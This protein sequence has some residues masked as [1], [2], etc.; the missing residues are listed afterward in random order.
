M[1][2]I[3]KNLKISQLIFRHL[4]D[5][6]KQAEKDQLKKIFQESPEYLDLFNKMKDP[7][8]LGKQLSKYKE[9]KLDQKWQTLQN[10]LRRKQIKRNLVFASKLAAILIIPVLIAL[11]AIFNNP[12]KGINYKKEFTA[13]A[14]P[15]SSKVQLITEKGEVFELDETKNLN[16]KD[17]LVKIEN[18]KSEL[19]YAP[20][21]DNKKTLEI[22]YHT[23]IVP[24][25][26]EHFL[27]LSDGTRIWVNSQSKLKYP[28]TFIGETRSIELIEGEIY[29]EVAHNKERP[30][31]VQTKE[32]IVKVL[33]T[34][35]N[36][37]AYQDEIKSY[38]TLVKGSISLRHKFEETLEVILKPGEQA[39]QID[40]N[41]TIKVKQVDIEP[42]IAWKNGNFIFAAD[43]MEDIFNQLSRWYGFE[44]AYAD[45]SVKDIKFRGNF[46]KNEGIIKILDLL[47]ETKK[48]KFE[49][50][51]K[52]IIVKR[53]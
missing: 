4:K 8:Y 5:E 47:E 31:T 43:R 36:I 53:N 50:Q 39:E 51:E 41:H 52:Q 27:T 3:N 32:G 46:R 26:G 38:V 15:G 40:V 11:Y 49:Y 23:L 13:R 10:K 12:E 19:F 42:I 34:S 18:N 25:G 29:L 37:R 35:F 7:D 1:K 21:Q 6:L 30:F 33:G 22:G 45:E 14:I 48:I 16:I 9:I 20:I 28:K 24:R 17:S 2:N 44:V